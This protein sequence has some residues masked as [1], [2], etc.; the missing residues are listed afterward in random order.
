MMLV[1]GACLSRLYRIRKD[2]FAVKVYAHRCT[3]AQIHVS[4]EIS[5]HSVTISAVERA[6]K[7]CCCG[8]DQ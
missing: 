2:L 3:D 7:L 8:L 5:F 6:L 1:T 4:C